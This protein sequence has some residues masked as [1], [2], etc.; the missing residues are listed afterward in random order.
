MLKPITFALLLAATAVVSAQAEI[1]GHYLETRT[2]QVYTGPCFAN[3][4]MGLAG[5]DAVMAWSINE[6]SHEGVDLTGLKV[7]VAVNCSTGQYVVR[8]ESS[9]IEMSLNESQLQGRLQAGKD[10]KI[11]TRKVNPNDCICMNE[12]AF[13]PPL[14]KVE[15]CMPAVAA[16]G[17]FQGRGL[18]STWSTPESRSAYVARFVY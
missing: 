10:V 2:C 9:P 14:A 12:I 1:R 7:V 3:G 18:G 6:G 11:V 5:R 4:E 17:E 13:F 8:V 16:E 15:T